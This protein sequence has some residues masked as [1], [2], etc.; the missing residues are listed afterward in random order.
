MVNDHGSFVASGVI[1]HP[2]PVALTSE[3]FFSKPSKMFVLLPLER[4]ADSTDPM[5]EA[6]A[7]PH[8]QRITCCLAFVIKSPAQA[9]PMTSTSQP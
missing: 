1:A 2:A 7:F 8:L 6:F 9:S 3:H 5:R 4:V